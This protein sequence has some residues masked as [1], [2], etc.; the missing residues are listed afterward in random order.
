MGKFARALLVAPTSSMAVQGCCTR[1]PLQICGV[2]VTVENH[3]LFQAAELAI[4]LAAA[5]KPA[6]T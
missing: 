1:G 6:P 5:D 3:E 4:Q 2:M